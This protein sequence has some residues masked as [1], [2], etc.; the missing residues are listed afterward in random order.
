ML[1]PEMYSPRRYEVECER[2]FPSKAPVKRDLPA[3]PRT[4][5]VEGRTPM[6]PLLLLTHDAFFFSTPLRDCKS[7][8][9]HSVFNFRLLVFV[10]GPWLCGRGEKHFFLRQGREGC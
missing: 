9:F 4:Q 7:F 5:T 8:V 6:A 1:F 2:I 10:G 3:A